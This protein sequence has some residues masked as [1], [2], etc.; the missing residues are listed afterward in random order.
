MKNLLKKIYFIIR[1]AKFE[2]YKYLI[3]PMMF[4]KTYKEFSD[5]KIK[6]IEDTAKELLNT[7]K[8][9]GRFG[10]GELS[11]M[12]GRNNGINNFEQLSEKLSERL[13]EVFNSNDEGFMVTLPDAMSYADENKFTSDSMNFWK[14]YLIKNKKRLLSHLNSNT[15][16]YNTSVTRPYMD[17]NYNKIA[18]VTYKIIK[19]IWNDKKILIIEG[20]ESRLG[21]TNSLFDNAKDIKRIECPSTNAFEA[22]DKIFDYANRFLK[23]HDDYL[24]LISLGPTATILSYDLF[25]NGHRSIDIG[26]IDVEYE[27]YLMGAKEKV[28]LPYKYVNEVNGGHSSLPVKDSKYLNE[29][30]KQIH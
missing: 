28:N 12:F 23:V 13:A 2:A 16:Y 29:I 6:S 11:W 22:Y 24:T 25:K 14:W 18:D 19:E 3:F 5:Y 27:W 21:V 7:D 20:S 1:D 8:S 4:D 30:V 15:V 26:H 9:I 10:D 17:Y